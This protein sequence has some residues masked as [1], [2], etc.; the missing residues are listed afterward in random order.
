MNG[1][2]NFDDLAERF[3]RNIYGTTKGRLRLAI[4][5]DCLERMLARLPAERPLRVLDAGC[6]PAHQARW[7]AERGHALLLCDHSKRMLAQA[8]ERL[9]EVEA[10]VQFVHAPL[11]SLNAE[12]HGRFDL[13]LLH[14]VLEWVAEPQAVL[15]RARSLLA[16]GGRLSLLFYNVDAVIWR[17]L[18]RGNFRKVASG[19]FGGHPHSLTPTHPR[20]PRE[21]E[22]WLA[23]LNLYVRDRCGVRVIHDYLDPD[24]REARS[25]EDLL[26]MERMFCRREPYLWLGRYMHLDVVAGDDARC[27]GCRDRL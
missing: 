23:E 6:G 21:V 12:E 2:R 22:G 8:R 26:A 1:D 17:N 9:A 7:L 10:D 14:A 25:F 13:I 16:E 4:V 11:Q 20:D 24:V 19:E 5:Q 27:E 18:L 15:A 3:G